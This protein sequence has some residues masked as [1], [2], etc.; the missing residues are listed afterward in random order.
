MTT[1]FEQQ[2]AIRLYNA[3][4]NSR[5]YKY[6]VGDNAEL[7]VALQDCAIFLC[8]GYEPENLLVFSGSFTLGEHAF[9]DRFGGS[10][11]DREWLQT[12]VKDA[13]KV[14]GEGSSNYTN[15]W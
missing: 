12:A 13:F 7:G 2:Q 11:D 14:A 4:F 1:N 9:L 15:K 5:A 3:Y 8:G 6:A 10:P